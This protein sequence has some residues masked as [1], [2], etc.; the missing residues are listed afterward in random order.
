MKTIPQN[1]TLENRLIQTLLRL[2]LSVLHNTKSCSL[3]RDSRAR[4]LRL[5]LSSILLA[6]AGITAFA[7]LRLA[8][9]YQTDYAIIQDDS[10]TPAEKRAAR[11]LSVVLRQITGA[12]FT[13]KPMAPKIPKRA[14]L[15]GP[16]PEARRLFPEV[17]FDQLKEE[18]L[19]VMTHGR[20]L[21]LAGGRPRGTLYAVNHFLQEYAGVRWW[22]PWASNVPAIA[23]LR[24]PRIDY[25]YCPVFESR[26]PFWYPAFNRDWAARNFSNSQ[27]GK[28]TEEEGGSIRYQGFVHTFYSLVPPDP[29]FQ[30]HP[31]WFSL[32]KGKRTADQAQL[33]LT[34]PALRDFVVQRVKE[35]IRQAPEAR[36][37]SV[38]QNDWHGACEC[39]RCRAL[40]EA[41]GSRAGTM[42]DFVNYIA[43]KI[44]SEFPQVAIDTLAY[45]YTRKPPRNL[46]PRSNVIIRLCS[47]E[48]NFAAPLTHASNRDFASDIEGWS[49][50]CQRLY[51][52]DYTTDF[53]HYAQPHPNWF[54][55]GPN[56]R[57][58][59]D[60]NVK[61]VFEQGAYQSYGA[62]MAELRAWVLG[63]L[64][65]RPELNDQQLILEFLEGYYGPASAKPIH[66]YMTLMSQAAQNYHLGCF[67]KT[68]APFLSYTNLVEAERLWEQAEQSARS[69]PGHLWRV[70]QARLALGYVWLSQWDRLQR[71]SKA[72]SIQWPVASSRQVLAEQWLRQTS[73]QGPSP[74]F[75]M[76]HVNESGVS[77]QKFAE[78]FLSNPKTQTH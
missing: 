68:D 41:E 52:W 45:Q 46:R 64:L 59:R 61:G 6:S 77:P 25:R 23:T 40:D 44:E 1:P 48:C 42:L 24:I 3:I 13:V 34:D 12:D 35:R 67:S 71:E 21:L 27:S 47:I 69:N 36:I 17:S 18:E 57:F 55:L 63:R 9:R 62:E 14:I 65:W 78:R 30:Q 39:D 26:D 33:C 10:A 31:E 11:E 43:S 72:T 74:W 20:R 70:R 54:V 28:L 38:S 8:S 16:S 2:R 66:Q 5:V 49:K 19:V 22:T 7:D 76:T 15:V 4:V 73:E 50:I 60:H 75:P 56:L 37:V 32:I 53:A 58:F 51:I 29:Y